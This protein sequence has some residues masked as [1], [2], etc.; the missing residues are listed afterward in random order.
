MVP[1]ICRQFVKH[2]QNTRFLYCQMNN[3]KQK[4]RV[5]CANALLLP[6][7]KRG[8]YRKC[9]LEELPK[10]ERWMVKQYMAA[11][12]KKAMLRNLRD[13]ATCEL[14]IKLASKQWLS[15]I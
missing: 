3:L 14:R 13:R 5:I 8:W 4:A 7:H 10:D 12:G 2:T 9:E 6:R 11:I 15:H 1:I